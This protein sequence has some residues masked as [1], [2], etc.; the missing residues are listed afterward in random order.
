MGT[1]ARS[2]LSIVAAGATLAG[3]GGSQPPIGVPGAMPQTSALAPHGGHRKSWM[4]PEAS[5]GDLLYV[6]DAGSGAVYMLTYPE[7]KV[8]ATLGG[9]VGNPQRV[10]S[11]R[12]GNVFVTEFAS[13]NN[14][15]QEYAHGGLM[16]ISDLTAPGEPEECSIDP[17]T[18][19]LAVAIYSYNSN[20]SGV[21][22]YPNAQGEPT[23]YSDTNVGIVTAASYDDSGDLFIAGNKSG[24]FT[25]AELPARSSTFIDIKLKATINGKFFEPIFWDGHHL[26]IGNLV[27][28]AKEYFIDRVTISGATGRVVGI[29]TLFLN[30]ANFSGDTSFFIKGDRVLLNDQARSFYGRVVSWAYPEGGSHLH[31]TR[32]FGSRYTAG[33]TVSVAPSR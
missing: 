6:S 26:A 16:P 23:F 18:G 1:L 2:A 30:H 9:L 13:G 28:Y 21:A 12:A 17:R 25:L 22:I 29:T 4:L 15:V 24:A 33:V 7:G 11:D 19:N 10:C 5:N 3:C 32:E 14:Q 27:E 20:P 31:T 8:V